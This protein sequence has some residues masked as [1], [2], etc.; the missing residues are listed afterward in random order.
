MKSLVDL[1]ISTVLRQTRRSLN[2]GCIPQLSLI[3]FRTE[4]TTR[5]TDLARQGLRFSNS[6]SKHIWTIS[7]QHVTLL[8][9]SLFR[10]YG[11]NGW[12]GCMSCLW[13]QWLSWGSTSLFIGLRIYASCI[14]HSTV[15]LNLSAT[16][17]SCN[18]SI[19]SRQRSVLHGDDLLIEKNTSRMISTDLIGSKTSLY[20]NARKFNKFFVRY[21]RSPISRGNREKAHCMSFVKCDSK[22]KD[23]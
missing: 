15:T 6:E 11:S 23:L 14:S 7:L 5:D 21:V 18:D 22:R 20:G 17:C 8:D 19:Q 2:G 12:L 3:L 9:A 13:Q 10:H 4:S 16:F 1:A